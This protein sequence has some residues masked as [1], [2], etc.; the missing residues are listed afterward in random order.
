MV[1]RTSRRP[2]VTSAPS[3]LGGSCGRAAPLRDPEL[4]PCPSATTS[5]TWPSWPTSTTARP[6]SSTRCSGS[7]AR[8]ARTRTSNERVMDSMDL[9]REKGITILAKNTAVRYGGVK[10]N[11]VDTP[12]PRRLRRRGRAGAHDGRRR[13]AAGRRLRRAAAAD[14]VRAAQGA[15][16]AA[17]RDPRRE[18]GRPARRAASPRS[19]TRSRSSSSTWTPTST[20]ST[21]RSCTRTRARGNA[22]L[23][24][25]ALGADLEPL[26][27]TLRRAH[28]RAGV[29]GRPSAAGARHEP[30]RL[31][32]TSAG[33]RS[34]GC[35]T[36][37]SRRGQQVA[38]CR[39]DGTIEQAKITE[40]YVTDALDRVE[41]DEA[42]P[43]EIVAIAG[44]AEVTIGETL[45]DPDDPRPLPITRVDEP[46]LSM[47][48]GDQHL[49]ARRAG[50]RQGHGPPAEEPPR[51][52]GRRQRLDPRGRH[53]AS[54][55]VGGAGPRRAAARGPRRDD[56]ARGVR[57]HRR[58]AAGRDAHGRRQAAW[59]RWSASR[60]TRPRTTS[61][62]ISQLLALR[63]G[64][65]EQMV[66]HGTGLDP[67]G[68]P[69]AGARAD[70]VP[71]RVH[72]RDARDRPAAPRV[73]GL[74]ALARRAPHAPERLARRRPPRRDDATSPC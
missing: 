74:R 63:K 54:R 5:A 50:R 49:A 40:L 47:T 15:R 7:P 57:A 8:S 37:R 19:C 17:A 39:A 56:A 66:N 11:I 71:H 68:V 18:Q 4:W 36:G 33:S 28:P 23:D 29:R 27:A 10:I 34:A 64:R 51:P 73:R 31:A 70:R 32:R 35:A 62:S 12:G 25:D 58:Q 21:S 38:W 3:R 42:G 14:A 13:A 9:E 46:S 30:R 53:R 61:G 41:A 43:G 22:A 65:M 67:H 16:V 1:R 24:R 52:G 26:F 48:I 60:S 69:G 20:R 44:I 6:R 45:A 59:S 55:D 72:D 2:M